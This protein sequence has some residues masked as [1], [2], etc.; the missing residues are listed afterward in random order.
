VQVAGVLSEFNAGVV[1]H[2]SFGGRRVKDIDWIA[3]L[4][5]ASGRPVLWTGVTFNK[6]DPDMW[7]QQLAY[8]APYFE[9][10]LRLFGNSNIVPF[11]NRFTLKNG[12]FL[13]GMPTWRSLM[14]QPVEERKEAM[15]RPEVRA[16]L[17]G[18][19]GPAFATRLGRVKI[20][21]A[22]LPAHATLQGK[23]IAE[24]TSMCEAA[25]ELD[26]MLDLALAEELE[27]VFLASSPI[28]D[29]MGEIIRSPYTIVGQSDA[30]AHVQFISNF[31]VC[32]SLLG[33]YVRERGLL[34]LEEAVH[35]LTFKVAS[36]FGIRDRGL[37][38][39][40]WAADLTLFDPDTVAAGDIEEAD[41][42]PGGFTRVLQH[43]HGMHYTIVNGEVLVEGGEYTGA[44]PGRVVRN[45]AA[46]EVPHGP[47]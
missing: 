37:I 15:A 31:G 4:G 9:Q 38:W 12:Q 13:D 46:V 33:E 32:T 39:P 23:T 18:E 40:G 47:A 28:E 36:I 24:L 27:T 43:A 6:D 3:R 17:H 44:H 11:A 22:H 14:G 1:Q 10:G 26:A 35:Q 7:R 2:S 30:G 20:L 25:S 8:L 21:R 42:Y 19:M 34:S 29:E 45:P 5:A 16:V 41:D